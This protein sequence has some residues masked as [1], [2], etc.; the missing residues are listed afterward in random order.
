MQ[1]IDVRPR[2]GR[3]VVRIRDETGGSF[4]NSYAT[5]QQARYFAAVYRLQRSCLRAERRARA[6]A[7]EGGIARHSL[8]RDAQAEPAMR[9]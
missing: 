6:A 4:E 3:W 8:A 2:A 5:E 1:R 9:F 7:G